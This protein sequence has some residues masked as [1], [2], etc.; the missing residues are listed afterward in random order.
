MTLRQVICS[1]FTRKYSSASRR[2]ILATTRRLYVAEATQDDYNEI[3]GEISPGIYEGID[4][5]PSCYRNYIRQHEEFPSRKRNFIYCLKDTDQI[6]FFNSF[7]SH[8]TEEDPF[9]VSTSG[10]IHPKLVGKG[11]MAE[12]INTLW[13][14]PKSILGSIS[15]VSDN[16]AQL[17]LS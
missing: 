11:Y 1:T 5:L 13:T 6:V 9:L 15:I 10:R 8:G 4:Y 16:N 7:A 3:I 12:A 2:N 17:N 14:G